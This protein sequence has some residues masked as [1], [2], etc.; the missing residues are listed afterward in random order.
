MKEIKPLLDDVSVRRYRGRYSIQLE[1]PPSSTLTE[2]EIDRICSVASWSVDPNQAAEGYEGGRA[3]LLKREKPITKQGISL[4]ALQVSGI[5]YVKIDFSKALPV[6]DKDNRFYP[7]C[8]MNFIEMVPGTKMST[9]FAQGNKVVITRPEYRALGTYTSNELAKT[10]RNTM[11]VSQTSLEK[12]A[13]PHVEAYGRYLDGELANS[14]G[15]FGFVVF[16]VP[17]EKRRAADSIVR[18]YTNLP[19]DKISLPEGVEALYYITLSHI[20]PLIDGLRELHD[21]AR[22]AHLQTHMSNFYTVN[23]KTY[24]MDWSTMRRL[25]GNREENLINRFI[26]ITKPSS[27]FDELLSALFHIDANK[28]AEVSLLVQKTILEIY[29]GNLEEEINLVDIVRRARNIFGKKF[30]YMQA[31][32]QW[33]KDQGIEGFPRYDYEAEKKEQERAGKIGR[34][35]PCHCGSGK[36]FKKC[37]GVN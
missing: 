29:S 33:I 28:K 35:S 9:G 11:I 15:Q 19:L 8:D 1:I 4:D 6:Y 37:C 22:L 23:G 24:L 31:F 25:E 32:T 26:D 12:I 3:V 2:Q 17:G 21:S 18:K 14:E 27:N 30:D 10:V 34:N 20:A 36:K 13:V 5:G 16:P 7:P